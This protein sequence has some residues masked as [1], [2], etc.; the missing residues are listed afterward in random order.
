L[1]HCL[2]TGGAGFIG[3]H[4]TT[5]LVNKSFKVTVIDN[6]ST[7]HL[8]NLSEVL[9]DITFIRGDIRDIELLKKSFKGVDVVFHQAALP[10]VPRSIKDPIV[11]NASNIDGTLN[12]LV[13]ARDAGVKRVICAASSSAYGDTEVLPKSE[14]MPS[15]PLSPYAVTKY[16]GELYSKVFSRVYGL[17]TVC[18]RYF[19]VFGP[20]QDPNSQYAAVIPKFII[21]MSK[22][23]SPRIYGDGEQSRDFT[24]IDNVVEANLLAASASDVSGE[25][26]N[27]A[28]GERYTINGLVD[29]LNEIFETNIEPEYDPPRPGDVRHSMAS[30]EKA[31]KFLGYKPV[32]TFQEGL[33]RTVEWF[34]KIGLTKI[35]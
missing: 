29:K 24:Y 22:G 30:I 16:V 5:A 11:S 17:E 26:F 27:I 19:N 3:S 6:L 18:L 4:L 1:K 10:S 13:A 9:D 25:V 34:T 2:V 12:V 33:R 35:P 31:E 15:N 23:E 14:E 21:A 8:E 32:V 7:G 28:C 20:R